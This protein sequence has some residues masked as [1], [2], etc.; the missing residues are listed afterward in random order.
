MLVYLMACVQLKI[1]TRRISEIFWFDV[2]FL[3]SQCLIYLARV[4]TPCCKLS[5]LAH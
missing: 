1:L 2:D 4:A 3:S 5:E